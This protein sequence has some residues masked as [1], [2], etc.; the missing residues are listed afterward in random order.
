[1][2][3]LDAFRYLGGTLDPNSYTGHLSNRF[4]TLT[5][6][7]HVSPAN[8]GIF[9]SSVADGFYSKARP[10]SWNVEGF[11]V[12]Q[13]I[14]THS[15]D[16]PLHFDDAH[17]VCSVFPHPCWKARC[18]RRLENA[19]GALADETQTQQESHPVREE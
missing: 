18:Y 10:L 5:A 1:M 2:R 8:S 3:G 12:A 11:R 13:H 17:V 7:D 19:T 16:A 6:G 4:A 9:S 15:S 14:H